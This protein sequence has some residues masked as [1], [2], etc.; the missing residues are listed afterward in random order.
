[1]VTDTDNRVISEIEAINTSD[2]NNTSEVAAQRPPWSLATLIAFRFGTCYFGSFGLAL[3]I[4]LIPVLLA[5]IGIDGPWSAMRGMLDTLRRPLE[6]V[7]SHLLGLDVSTTQVGSDSAFQWSAIFC[8]AVLAVWATLIWTLLDLRRRRYDRLQTWVW[9]VLRLMLATGMFYFGMAKVI[10][11]QMPFVL[12]RLV[13]PF[14]NFSP[15]GVLWA[16][17][18]ISQPYQML[19]GVAEVLG[20][21][22]LL[23]PRTAAAGALVCAFDLTQVFILN[24][25]YDIRLK[26]V[27]SQL[28]LLSLF[29]LA[30]YAR[31]LF[32][33][34]FTHRAV[35]ATESVPLFASPRA[36]RVALIAQVCVGLLLLAA[37]GGQGWQ[38]F[39]RPTPNLYGIWQVDGFSAE[40]YRR[41]PLLTDELR[42]R[43]VIFDRPFLMSD[44]VMLTVQHMDD[45]FEVFG[46]TIDARTHFIDLSNRIELGSFKE[47][48]TRIRLTYWWPELGNTERIVIDGEDFAGHKIHAWFTRMDQGSFPLV[49]RGFNW[50]QEQPHNR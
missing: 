8:I 28:L 36:N 35:A 11:T 31:R 38:Q 27:S 50:V 44:P 1:V 13:E 33:A 41:D 4:G 25:T 18:G 43:R 37:F 19:L 48:P 5:G 49:E 46:G 26:S 9:T 3:G 14:G 10:P 21:L 22:L 15:T 7:G 45:S 47:T 42:W 12:N 24:M 6:W 30:P 2:T 29:L 34:L 17:V 40:G 20:G 16:Q 39:T 32:A 23:L